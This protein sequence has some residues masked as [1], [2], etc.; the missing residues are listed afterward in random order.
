MAPS[1]SIEPEVITDDGSKL[2]A[3]HKGAPVKAALIAAPVA[4]ELAAVVPVPSL[5]L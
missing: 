1:K 3:F 5:R 2:F 4:D